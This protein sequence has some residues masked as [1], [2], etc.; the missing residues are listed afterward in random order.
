MVPSVTD[1]VSDRQG[2]PTSTGNTLH[3]AVVGAAAL[4][5]GRVLAAR[6]SAPGQGGSSHAAS[7]AG[8]WEFPGGKVERG[9][10]D[11]Q[12]LRREL[13]EELGVDAA[14]GARVGPQVRLPRGDRVLR[15]YEATLASEPKALL[16]HDMLRWMCADDVCDLDWL[17]PDWPIVAAVRER[18]LDGVGLAGGAVGG[19]VRVAEIEG[20]TVRRPT[21]EWTPAVH[22]LLGFLVAA[23]LP[24][25][26]SA[27]GLD[28]RGR[29]VLDFIPG[30][31][32]ADATRVPQRFRT[33][34]VLADV[35]HW[36][37][38]LHEATAESAPDR[39]DNP[40]LTRLR[41][42]RRWR[43][44]LLEA[45]ERQ[46][47]CHNDVNPRNVVL[48]ERG[49]LAGVLDW[50][51]AA[52]GSPLDDVAFAVWQFVL[53]HGERPE[54]EA[55][56]VVTLA[57]AYG[58]EPIAVLDRVVPRLRGALRTIRS[59]AAAGDPGLVAL[60]DRGIPHRVAAGVADLR[61]RLP[62]LRELVARTGGARA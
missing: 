44:G 11:A 37:R 59:G 52:P 60:T 12:A 1:S 43:R 40:A 50:D 36:L 31:V 33:E 25:V 8:R 20:S 14:I 58:A 51:M 10:S 48:D 62:R 6:R 35:G 61:Q 13:R 7:L 55:D 34:A 15:V 49:R 27:H 38:L 53:S 24:G 56:G 4:R 2:L 29:E 17:D 21:G 19:A 18:L 39:A 45:S 9:E 42:R 16:D 3:S 54:R 5:D 57:S 30:D 46:V 47:I 22:E 32:M 23:G 41:G 28:E 26:P